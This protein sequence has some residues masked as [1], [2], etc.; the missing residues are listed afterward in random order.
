LNTTTLINEIELKN[1]YGKIPFIITKF[2]EDPDV[3]GGLKYELVKSQL[4]SNMIDLLR[5]ENLIYS[6]FGVWVIKNFGLTDDEIALSPGR[7]YPIDTKFDD[8]EPSLEHV[9]ANPGY[10]EIQLA[11]DLV[12]KNIMRNMGLPNG[13]LQDNPGLQSGVAML[14]DRKELEEA[15]VDDIE[16][17]QIFEKEIINMI[18]TVSNSERLTSYELVDVETDFVETS[19]MLEP[20][21]EF[22]LQTSYFNAGLITPSQ[23]IVRTTGREFKTDEEA[24]EFINKNKDFKKQIGVQD[25][26]TDEGSTGFENPG[27]STEQFKPTNAAEGA[28][29][30]GDGSQ[31]AAGV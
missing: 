10:N 21:K 19:A 25:G 2:E 9:S 14:I 5:D 13:M 11:K 24:I 3:Y 16:A 26:Q 8:P 7:I 12:I 17:L 28:N 20:D 18:L 30:K 4:V 29:Q 1:P 27:G 23:Y 31:A 6:G 22:E 15:R